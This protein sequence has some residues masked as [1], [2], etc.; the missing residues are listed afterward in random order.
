MLVGASDFRFWKKSW[1]LS[2]IFHWGS[3]KSQNWVVHYTLYKFASKI[4]KY[5]TVYQF[6]EYYTV[7]SILIFFFLVENFQVHKF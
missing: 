1:S 2:M 3:V 6:L 7:Y 4:C 5:C